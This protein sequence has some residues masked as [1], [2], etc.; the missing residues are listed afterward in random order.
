MAL[1]TSMQAH[2]YGESIFIPM[3]PRTVGNLLKWA[4]KI[5]NLQVNASEMF[6]HKYEYLSES[7]KK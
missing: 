4:G 2:G 7:F 6:A 1:D 3:L 5:L